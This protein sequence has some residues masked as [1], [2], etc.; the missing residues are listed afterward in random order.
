MF[1]LTETNVHWK[2]NHIVTNFK[3]I[4][5]KAWPE[6][7]IA[8]C[9]FESE[10]N[11]NTDSKPWATVTISVNKLSSTITAQG[12]YT[13]GMK[14]WTYI[15]ILGRDNQRTTIIT[16]YRPCNTRI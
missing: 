14:R 9:T 7:K 2:R 3:R 4:L 12:K 8:Y 1:S 5:E 16:I 6:N 10:L 15:T 11:W 13:L